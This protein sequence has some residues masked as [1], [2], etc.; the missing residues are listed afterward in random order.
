M[1][2]RLSE[3]GQR[4]KAYR[5]G[6]GLRAE[7]VAVRLGISRAAVYRI[8]EGQVVKVETLDRL[9]QLL[10]TS[11]ASLLGAGAEY[12][13]RALSYFERMRQLEGEA[14]QVVSHFQPIS[15]LLATPAY[16]A[17][18]RAMLLES[19]PPHL[20]GNAEALAEIDA[21]LAVLEQRHAAARRRRPAIVNLIAVPEIDRFLQLGMIGSFDLPLD[22]WARRRRAAHA[23]V[24]HI[25]RL[26]VEQ[27]MGIQIGVIEETLP[28]ITFQLFR[29]PT[30]TI[31]AVSPF[32]LGEQPNIR[33]GVAMVT[34]AEEPVG[35]YE[36]LSA[37]LW[38]Q[39]LKGRE[40]AQRLRELLVRAEAT[41]DAMPERLTAAPKLAR[42][43]GA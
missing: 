8:E 6:A 15:Y 25:V 40:G 24:E 30:R 19:L 38:R 21:V 10:G 43:V 26:L 22:E 37:E 42:A 5:L 16:A 20:V 31:L 28:N 7:D 12:H 11:V 29:H 1:D 23:E 3:I 17:H 14:D 2:E 35:L 13:A 36:R 41:L 18:L 9:A 33:A 39:A 4:L 34:E 32:R 27:P